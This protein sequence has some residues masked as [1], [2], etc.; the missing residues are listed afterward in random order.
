MPRL[1][2][3]LACIVCSLPI[4]AKQKP[5][6]VWLVTHYTKHEVY[7]PMRDG[8]RLFTS[9][10]IPKSNKEKHP[11]LLNRTPYSVAP[12]GD[13]VYK[14][15]WDTHYMAYFRKNYIVVLQDV[16]GRMMSEGEFMDVR[17]YLSDKKNN[18]IDEATDTY[19]AV[20]WLV[21]NVKNNNG[22][23]G[24]WGISYP[25]FYATM[26]AMCGHPAVKAVSPQA[27]VTEWFIG[28]DFHHNGAFML[29]DGFNFY[30]SFGKPRPQPVS[31]WPAGFQYYTKDNYKFYLETAPLRNFAK[32]MGDSISFWKD[33]YNHPNY[34]TWW[35]VRNTRNHVQHIPADVATLVVGGLFDAEDC[36][37]AWALYKSIEQKAGNN[38]KLV[39]GPWS[40]GGWAR[41]TGEYLGNVRFGMKNSKWYQENIEIP[42]FDYYLR[43]V[44]TTDNINEATI[45]FTGINKWHSFPQWPP[46]TSAERKLYLHAGGTLSYATPSAPDRIAH[47]T[48]T[49]DPAHPVPYT[50]DVH[51]KRTSEYMT[52]D[53]R[54]ASRRA[55]VLT[56][57][58][59]ALDHDIAVAGP[60]TADL[61][62]AI[63]TTDADFVVKLIDV[64]PD[65]FTYSDSAHGKGN[66]KDYPMGGYQ[67][68][69]RGEIMRGRYRNSF[70]TPEAFVPG[71]IAEVKYKLPDV[72]HVFKKGHRIMVQ[73]QSSWF[74]LADRNPQQFVDI[75]HCSES[76][77]VPA[78]IT[79]YSG[80]EHPSAI[81]LTEL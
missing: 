81:I 10:Y 29:M 66:G 3:L 1:L 70:E 19:D 57:T 69:V 39:M 68:L 18:E 51:F 15:F 2:L 38:N 50:E 13:K 77:F 52:D 11:L 17:P 8:K 32:L 6:S 31:T 56:F 71:Q 59:G 27:P 79:I 65:D 46:V 34:D 14:S 21:K 73:V 48:Y 45:F 5:D 24:V 63:S 49:S 16:R 26:A 76:A 36:Y 9:I 41:G 62:T 43:N 54:F 60:V 23:V 53:Q 22:M 75:Y 35:Q 67:M 64:F 33:L 40:H 7:I 12:Y 28:D 42:F 58:T 61:F 30:A 47:N 78:D 80:H 72:A 74:P 55:D 4:A 25:G 37:G 44:G 20:D